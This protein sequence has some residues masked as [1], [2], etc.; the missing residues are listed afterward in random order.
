MSI[1]FFSP[2]ARRYFILFRHQVSSYS[3]RYTAPLLYFCTLH[4]TV[5][6]MFLLYKL[7]FM[8]AQIEKN[9]K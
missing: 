2:R 6:F 7:S 1:T 3:Y 8:L 9:L 4:E 5:F